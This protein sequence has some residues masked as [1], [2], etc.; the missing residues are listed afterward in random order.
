VVVFDLLI[1]R[2][3]RRVVSAESEEKERLEVFVM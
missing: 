2:R 3:G 1:D